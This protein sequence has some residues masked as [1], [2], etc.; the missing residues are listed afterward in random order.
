MGRTH[1]K[2]SEI[3]VDEFDFSGLV[4]AIDIA[5]EN[6]VAEVTAFSDTDATFVD[7]KPS[8]SITLNGLY[9][10]D[11]D[12]EMFA[13]LTSSNRLLTVSPGDSATAGGVAYFG[14]G[15]ITSRPITSNI[16]EAILLNTTWNGNK[17]L[18]RGKILYR[19]IATAS[20]AG[21]GYHLGAVASTEQLIAFQHVMSATAG[22]TLITIIESDSTSAFGIASTAVTFT[23]VSTSD[24]A[25]R[26][27]TAGAMTDTWYRTHMEIT[28]ASASYDILVVA[29]IAPLGSS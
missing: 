29:G 14:Q 18:T 9:S 17:P 19:G 3:F 16:G 21:T 2:N 23:T 1:A 11:Y 12:A 4:N 5:I 6:P 24:I 13:D 22:T 10:T 26:K 28:G 15:D 20:V 27:A 8:F 25:E 7:G